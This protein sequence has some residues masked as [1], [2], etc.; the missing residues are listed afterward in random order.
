MRGD[1]LD[2]ALEAWNDARRGVIA[3]ARNVP[4]DR[5]GFRP[6]EEVRSVSELLCHIMEV[7]RMMAGEL[8]REDGDF[9][10]KPLPELLEEHAAGVRDLEEKEAIVDALERTLEEDLERFRDVGQNHMLDSIRR[11][12]GEK[13]TRLA[14]LHHGI[15][16]EMYHR[17]QLCTYERLMGLVPALTKRIRGESS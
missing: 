16:Q 5:Y 4:S 6:V 14:W 11:F 12:D 10:R 9:R 17:G 15:A 13:G 1:L 2:E 8:C 7:S 3:E